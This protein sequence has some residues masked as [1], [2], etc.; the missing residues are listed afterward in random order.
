MLKDRI[1]PE[2][3]LR[4]QSA[5][6]RSIH[7]LPRLQRMVL[8]LGDDRFVPSLR[9]FPRLNSSL[10]LSTPQ[11]ASIPLVYTT[12]TGAITLLQISLDA[13]NPSSLSLDEGTVVRPDDNRPLTS[14]VWTPSDPD[15]L[16]YT[17]PGKVTFWSSSVEEGKRGWE[18]EKTMLISKMGD[19]VGCSK[20]SG[21]AG[22][23]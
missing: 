13:S 2:D 16:V 22:E 23:C 14:L 1:G 10:T 4:S 7:L 8:R 21:C 18:G 6:R 3:D 9:V 20:L 17:Q 19:W 12:P 5:T 15:L 11:T